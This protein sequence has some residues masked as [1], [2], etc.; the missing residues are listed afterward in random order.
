MDFY[1]LLRNSTS[2]TGF[3]GPGGKEETSAKFYKIYWFWLVE[4]KGGDFYELLRILPVLGVGGKEETST[5]CYEFYWFWGVEGKGGDFL[6][7]H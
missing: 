3:R 7:Q 5:N 6:L 2:C 1:E 4:D